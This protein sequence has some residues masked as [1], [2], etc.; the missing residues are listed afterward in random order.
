MARRHWVWFFRQLWRVFKLLLFVALVAGAVYWF[1]FSPVSVA[2]HRVDT[3]EIVAEVMGTGTLEAHFKSTVSPRISGRL[4]EVLVDMGESVTAGQVLARLDDVELKP[5]V[6]MAEASATVA[7]ATLDRLQ[8]DRSQALAV[9]E[10]TKAEHLRSLALLPK[11][12]ISQSDMDK[13]TADW[14]TA[15]AAVARAEAAIVEGHK[16]L[17][18]AE[19]NLAYRKALLADTIVVAPVDGL[20]VERQRDPGDIAVPGSAVLSLISTKELW[21]TAWVDETEMSRVAIGQPARVVF[22]SEPDGAY[23]G[24]V[25]RLGRQADRETREFPVDVRVLELPKNWAVGQRAEVYIETARKTGATVLPTK[26]ILW[27]EGKPG[28]LVR[29][30]DRAAWRGLTLGLAGRDVVEVISGLTPGDAIVL[31]ADNKTVPEGR[32]ITVR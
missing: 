16:Q 3:G 4:Q 31:P 29:R 24:E 23:R 20:I 6:E 14:K 11:Q 19:R 5:Q 30:A 26:F 1:K 21:I 10:Q 17:I 18:A 22:R 13:A 9:L 27:R 8:A 15:Q 7:K 2:E 28:V 12:A 32:R 25:T